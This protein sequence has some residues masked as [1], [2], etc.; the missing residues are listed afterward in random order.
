MTGSVVISEV[1]ALTHVVLS[2]A[3]KTRAL[4]GISWYHIRYNVTTEVSGKHA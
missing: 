2:K 4:L 1:N 3:E